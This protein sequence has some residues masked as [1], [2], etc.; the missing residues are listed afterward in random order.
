MVKKAISITCEYC[1]ST[2]NLRAVFSKLKKLH[3]VCEDH[4]PQVQKLENQ[5]AGLRRVD[6]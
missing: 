2:S 3:I 1:S 6:L 5:F 4:K